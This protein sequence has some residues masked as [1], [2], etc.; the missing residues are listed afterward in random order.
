MNFVNILG[1]FA[2]NVKRRCDNNST[3]IT[4]NNMRCTTLKG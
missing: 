3:N 4:N 1:K 2:K